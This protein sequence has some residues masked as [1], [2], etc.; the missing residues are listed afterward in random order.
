MRTKV[1]LGRVKLKSDNRN[2]KGLSFS[3]L[4]LNLRGNVSLLVQVFLACT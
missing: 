2:A 4:S 1:N 3:L